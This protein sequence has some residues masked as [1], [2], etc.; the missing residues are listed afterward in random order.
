MKKTAHAFRCYLGLC[1]LLAGAMIVLGFTA[2][3]AK[4]G[5]IDLTDKIKQ[6]PPRPAL[7]NQTVQPLTMQQCAQCHIGVFNTLKASGQRH[8][9]ECTFCHEVYHTY[10]PGK[11]EYADALPKCVDCHGYPHGDKEETKTCH[12]CHSNAHAPLDLPG[13]KPNLC[14]DCH[15]APPKALKDFPS[16]H[17]AM[18]CGDCHTKHGFIPSCL[19]CH[20]K[21]GGKPYHLVGVEPKVCMTCHAG[22]H[23]P[24]VITY[25]ENT[26][27]EYCG[28]CHKNEGHAQIYQTLAKSKSKHNTEITCASCHDVHGKI[29]SCAKCHDQEGHRAKLK[30]EDC[31]RCH[32]NPHDPLNISFSIT[33]PKEVCGGC[34]TEVFN[35]L[36]QNKTRHTNQTCS[37]C[38]PKHGE[39][40]TCQKCHGNPHGEAMVAQFAG[41]CAGCHDIAHKI[42]GRMKDDK[43]GSLTAEGRKGALTTVKK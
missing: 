30:D 17:T 4:T 38:H 21:E 34:H 33:E 3:Q 9:K 2:A 13:V 8:Q 42:K 5:K 10:A 15:S 6:V 23:K 43:E 16:K 20:S 18:A 36:V 41:K 11:V 22:P 35:T 29:P 19:S 26:P 32:T 7:F 28:T 24:M 37:F 39:I 1:C 14:G 25:A 31:L 40:P 12:N 27:K